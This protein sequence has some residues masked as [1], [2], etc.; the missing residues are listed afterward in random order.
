MTKTIKYDKIDRKVDEIFNLC[1][2]YFMERDRRSDKKDKLKKKQIKS[3]IL[4]EPSYLTIE[5]IMEMTK[6]ETIK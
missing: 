2:F 3:I 5:D 1:Y 6:K 4:S